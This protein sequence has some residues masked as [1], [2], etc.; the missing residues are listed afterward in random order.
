[1]ALASLPPSART[2]VVDAESDDD[3][4]HLARVAG[5]EVVVRAWNGFVDARRYALARVATPWTFFLDADEA[6]DA[7]ARAA[8]AACTPPDDVDGFAFARTTYF[9][10][11]PMRAGAWGHDRPLRLV[12]TGR[13]VIVARP[14]AG[15]EAE[16]HERPSVPGRVA[17]M[18]GTIAHYSY[19]SLASYREKFARYT[20]LE[21]R[22]R[23]PSRRSLARALVIAPLRLAWLV[24]VRSAWRDG[25][26]GLFVAAASSA[27]PVVVAAKAL[28][29]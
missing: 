13:A 6:L 5:V 2:L 1:M 11:A 8:L 7:A 24:A 3:T 12:R 28:R 29:P 9:C 17:R 18:A 25:A 19:P 20:S 15:G 21:A 26:R 27:Y 10:G 14:A 23:R 16:L 22:G 4:V